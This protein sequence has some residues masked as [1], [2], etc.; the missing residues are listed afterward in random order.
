MSARLVKNVTANTINLPSFD[1]TIKDV[2]EVFGADSSADFFLIKIDRLVTARFAPT[3]FQ[4]L[5]G[6]IPTY[7]IPQPYAPG[8][9][10]SRFAILMTVNGIPITGVAT[11]HNGF[12]TL[13][14]SVVSGFQNGDNVFLIST[15]ISYIV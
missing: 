15:N 5:T 4:T 8:K 10:I 14:P 12:I 1:T 11:A 13:A 7:P 9:I 6:G 2:N 3:S